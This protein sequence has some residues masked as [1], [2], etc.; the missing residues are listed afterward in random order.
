MTRKPADAVDA[1]AVQDGDWVRIVPKSFH[2]FGIVHWERAPDDDL[3]KPPLPLLLTSDRKSVGP[4]LF[5]SQVPNLLCSATVL[6]VLERMGTKGWSARP[7]AHA[8]P[9]P[10]RG[11]VLYELELSGFMGPPLPSCFK[12]RE[13]DGP[14]RPYGLAGSPSPPVVLDGR[15]WTGEPLCYTAWLGTDGRYP[16]RALTARGDFVRALCEEVSGD[17]E[18]LLQPVTIQDL[19]ENPEKINEPGHWEHAAPA[20]DQPTRWQGSVL[21]RIRET[22]EQYR[23][24]LPGPPDPAEAARVFREIEQRSGGKLDPMLRELLLAHN[25]PSLFDGMLTFFSIGKRSDKN[26][27][28][29]RR[30]DVVGDDLLT[31]HEELPAIGP[32]TMPEGWLLFAARY[33]GE[34]P[35]WALTPEGRVRLLLR[36]GDVGGPD[37]PFEAWLEDQVADLEWIWD[38]PEALGEDRYSW[39][40]VPGK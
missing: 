38:N 15:S 36:T 27:V 13:D 7:L 37:V 30:H 34:H 8:S 5:Y 33:A 21:Q 4:A 14:P 10:V 35:I 29:E 28:P 23:H 6:H 18:L 20:W 24:M 17:P 26:A 22:R 40:D 1:A 9:Y 19:A 3:D 2:E 39:L 11:V 31:A 12:K 32:L 16:Y 25:G